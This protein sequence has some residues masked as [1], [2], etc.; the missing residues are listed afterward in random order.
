MR[1]GYKPH[2]KHPEREAAYAEVHARP[3][4]MVEAPLCVSFIGLITTDEDVEIHRQLLAELAGE[5]GVPAPGPEATCYYQELSG[6]ELRW[7]RHQEFCALAILAPC[8][9]SPGFEKPALSCLPDEWVDRIAGK[10]VVGFHALMLDGASPL[11]G[12]PSL[13]RH[14]SGATVFGSKIVDGR[15]A[16]WTSFRL[17]ADGFTRFV[18]YNNGLS[19]FQAGRTLQRML[20]VETYWV[21]AMLGLPVARRLAPEVARLDTE[22]AELTGQLPNLDGQDDEKRLIRELSSLAARVEALRAGSK[23][24]F[25]ATRA[26]YELAS[27]RLADLREEK[28]SGVSTLS[29]FLKRRLTPAVKTCSAVEE[30]LMDLSRRI[31][32]ASALLRTNVDLSLQEQ[33]QELLQSMNRRAAMQLRLQQTVEGLSVVVISYYTIGLFKTALE[34]LK[35]AGVEIEPVPA[36]GIAIVPVVL[37]V[38]YVVRKVRKGLTS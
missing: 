17:H 32:R 25:S 5:A 28:F 18:I 36:A 2:T 1:P 37:L 21:M 34:A 26:Y 19:R 33:N 23:Y 15:A 20:E 11:P 7:E 38:W 10:W 3:F 27:K 14:F 13:D 30:Q 6:S 29:K 8:S 22:L 12:N 31:A 4:P 35:H 16:V 24:R 9:Q